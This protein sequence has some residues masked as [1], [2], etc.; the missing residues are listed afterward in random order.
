MSIVYT[1]P[2]KALS[3]EKFNA[4]TKKYH[5]K[6]VCWVILKEMITVRLKAW[7]RS[8]TLTL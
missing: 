2:L 4:W 1:A 6:K 7:L 8:L 3:N 5:D